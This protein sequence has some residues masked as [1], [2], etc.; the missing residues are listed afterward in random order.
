M[1]YLRFPRCR[2][3]SRDNGCSPTA[4]RTRS[5]GCRRAIRSGTFRVVEPSAG[6]TYEDDDIVLPAVFAD[7]SGRHADKPELIIATLE[8]VQQLIGGRITNDG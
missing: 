6:Q 7:L 4:R 1:G 3:K 2:L 8:E 5:R